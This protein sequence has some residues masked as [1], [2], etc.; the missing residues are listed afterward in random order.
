MSAWGPSDHRPRKSL[1]EHRSIPSCWKTCRVD[2]NQ[3]DYTEV[4]HL[5]KAYHGI[6]II[7]SLCWSLAQYLPALML[8]LTSSSG[9]ISSSF[10][11]PPHTTSNCSATPCSSSCTH[12]SSPDPASTSED[13]KGPAGSSVGA[14][15]APRD[16]TTLDLSLPPSGFELTRAV[17]SFW[18]RKASL[19]LS[20][21]SVTARDSACFSCLR[22]FLWI[23]AIS[24]P[25]CTTTCES[26]CTNICLCVSTLTEI[27]F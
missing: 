14:F 23:K 10:E 8:P 2:R 24:M 22:L 27:R 7:N 9:L 11:I 12:D 19:C 20:P 18:W 16:A 15:D 1:Q 17:P 13:G 25:L 3:S 4:L 21:A 6:V 5:C 26:A